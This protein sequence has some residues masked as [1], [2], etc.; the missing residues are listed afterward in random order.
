MLSGSYNTWLVIASLLVAILASYTALDLAGRVSATPG[1][2]SRGWLIGGSVAMGIGIWSM[3]F[4]GMLAFNLPIP[5]GYD[6]AITFFSLLIAIASSAFALWIVCQ[7]QLSMRRLCLG[8]VLM[9]SGVSAMHYTGMMAMRMTPAIHYVP[10]LFVLSVLIAVGA[11]GTAL[12]IAFHLRQ[13]S[14]QIRL[15]RVGAALV[16]GLA[17]AGMHYTGMAAAKFP[18]NSSCTMARVGFAPSQMAPLVLVFAVGVL[19]IALITSLLEMRLESRTAS[20]TTS[21]AYANQELQFLA[22]HDNLTKLPNR[23]LLEDRLEQEMQNAKREL[24]RFAVLFLDLDG[25]K[26][27]NDA[28]GHHAGD[29]LLLQV[30]DRIRASIRARDTL[31]RIGGDEFVVLANASEPADAATFAAKLV[32]EI[33]KPFMIARHEVRVSVSIGI[34]VFDGAGNDHQDLLKSADT[35]MYH[36]KAMGRNTYC[37]FD[38]SMNDDAQKELQLVSDLRTALEKQE[39]VLFYQPTIDAQTGAVRGAEALLRWNHPT[40][41]MAPPNLFI[42]AAERTGLIVPMGEWVLNEACRQMSE[43]HAAGFTHWTIAVNLS[44][45]QFNHPGLIQMVRDTLQIHALDPKYLTLEIT[46]ST[47]MRDVH[48]SLVIL[49]QLHGM[50]VQIS[51]DDFGTGYS[52]LLYLKRLPASELKIDRGFVC[53]L[54]HDTEDAAIIAAIVAL[55]RTLNLRIVAEGVETNEQRGFLT[56]LGCNLLQGF[57]FGKPMPAEQFYRFAAGPDIEHEV[58]EIHPTKLSA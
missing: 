39:L 22:L 13:L 46:E 1:K 37:F 18:M 2:A 51:I 14:Q 7:R 52:S 45:V 29:L 56:R 15:Y 38:A 16:M 54:A 42:P 20:L 53:D 4:I 10:S 3:H 57:L 41:G 47:A 43:W 40:R 21:L 23:A 34:A 19:S 17:I 58:I 30:A 27:I 5:M 35:A 28:F 33:A 49:K 48:A 31:A 44:A 24:K 55:G 6:P 26:Q 32:E 12:W 9:G 50:G 11:S 36:A 25:F 8:A